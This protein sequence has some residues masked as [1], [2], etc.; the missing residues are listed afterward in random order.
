MEITVDHKTHRMDTV[1]K[2]GEAITARKTVHV[3]GVFIIHPD[4]KRKFFNCVI[5]LKPAHFDIVTEAD[6]TISGVFLITSCQEVDRGILGMT[7]YRA[8]LRS[9]GAPVMSTD[10]KGFPSGVAVLM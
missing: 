2:N 5:D 6:K 8:S 1:E 10:R 9:E 4:S 3:D 7:A